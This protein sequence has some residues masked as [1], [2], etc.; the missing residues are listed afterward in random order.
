MDDNNKPESPVK[1]K[2]KNPKLG[3]IDCDLCGRVSSVKQNAKNYFYV[4]CPS[5]GVDMRKGA[6]LQ[7]RL[8]KE[9]Q[10][11]AGVTPNLPPNLITDQPEKPAV[12][13]EPAGGNPKQEPK[14]EPKEDQKQEPKQGSNYQ[15]LFG[16]A[17][18]VCAAILFIR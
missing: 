5:C 15:G 4:G 7:T 14:Q 6:L 8:Y 11:L 3:E 18:S 16:L 12:T 17:C 1:P 13:Q 9:T 10:W 2:P